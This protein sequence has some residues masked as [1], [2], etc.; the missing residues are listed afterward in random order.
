[1]KSL[2]SRLSLRKSSKEEHKRPSI[3]MSNY[4]SSDN[5]QIYACGLNDNYQCGS[6]TPSLV[7]T[8]QKMSLPSHGGI[9]LV[10]CGRGNVCVVTNEDQ[11][12]LSGNHLLN[13]EAGNFFKIESD[14]LRGKKIVAISCGGYHLLLLTDDHQLFSYGKNDYG[15]LCIDETME[16][17]DVMQVKFSHKIA[18]IETGATH[19]VILTADG[20]VYMCGYNG[21][22]QL[23]TADYQS[24]K[25]LRKCAQIGFKV[26]RVSAGSLHT[27]F[28]TTDR[29]CYGVGYNIYGQLGDGTQNTVTTPVQMVL[30][31]DTFVVNVYCGSIHTIVRTCKF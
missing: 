30:P 2:F 3:P 12:L 20:D 26:A 19:S 8:L 6:K 27:M 28:V 17:A 29:R 31:H 22:G 21:Y 24:H 13:N 9:K 23:C 5:S 7:P 16:S 11:V 4:R 15:Q 18:Q 25:D 14:K 1:M 10:S